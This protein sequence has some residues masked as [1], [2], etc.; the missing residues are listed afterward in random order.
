MAW[1]KCT[2]DANSQLSLPGDL[3]EAG[4]AHELTLAPKQKSQAPE[5]F[6]PQESMTLAHSCKLKNCSLSGMP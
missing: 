2:P 6:M 5:S 3:L 4:A 1:P